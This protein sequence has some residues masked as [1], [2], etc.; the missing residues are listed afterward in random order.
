MHLSSSW[1]VEVFTYFGSDTD[2]QPQSRGMFSVIPHCVKSSSLFSFPFLFSVLS[3]HA[4]MVLHL[5]AH[6]AMSH[7]LTKA[8]HSFCSSNIACER[9]SDP[10]ACGAQWE[11]KRALFPTDPC[12]CQAKASLSVQWGSLW[13]CLKCLTRAQGSC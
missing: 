7:R 1:S 3:K 12:S 8:S 13:S 2:G 10:G 9:R 6:P 5:P 4:E 11:E